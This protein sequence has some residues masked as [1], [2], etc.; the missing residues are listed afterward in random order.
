LVGF[1]LKTR[2]LTGMVVMLLPLVA[3]LLVSM[4]AFNE[5]LAT[6]EEVA[7]EAIEEIG[8]VADLE[9]LLED[10]EWQLHDLFRH[11]ERFDA[12][13]FDDL[14]PLVELAYQRTLQLPF[15]QKTEQNAVTKSWNL[16]GRVAAHWRSGLPSLALQGMD[17]VQ[18]AQA[19][20]HLGEAIV[21]LER[22]RSISLAEIESGR[23]QE[24]HWR[25]NLNLF[26]PLV[27]SFGIIIAVMIGFGL[28]KSV[29][30]PVREL[31]AAARCLAEGQLSHRVSD[32]SRDELGDLARAF[33]VM[34]QRLEHNHQTLENLSSVDYL[35]GLA[36]V[37]EFYRLFH[38]ETRRAQRYGHEF[39]LLI[40][41]IDLFKRIND[42]YGHQVGDLVLQ[43]VGGRLSDLV[44][45]SDHVARIGGDEFAIILTETPADSAWE[46][47]GRIQQFFAQFHVE[48]PG[49]EGKQI[50]TTVSIGLAS[51]PGDARKANDLFAEADQALYRSK[52]GGRNRICRAGA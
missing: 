16:W 37:R 8:P 36:N 47:G 4:L 9:D 33:N 24:R 30:A 11:P 32:L 23:S 2:L 46:L 39:S 17:E 21:T 43:E 48:P 20:G 25:S 35:T 38:E 13:S 42:S 40:L 14:V 28:A 22:M 50:P 34:A 1:S 19:A 18:R 49:L 5:V 51:Y 41:D 27:L 44:R 7:E 52:Q 29:L 10:V 12:G 26:M 6:L 3:V 45:T 15:A 31:E